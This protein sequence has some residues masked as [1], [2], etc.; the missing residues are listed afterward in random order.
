ME[1]GL[2]PRLLHSVFEGL[3]S[4]FRANVAKT[5]ICNLLKLLPR[6]VL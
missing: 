5:I 3:K 4:H 6:I 1:V 2:Q